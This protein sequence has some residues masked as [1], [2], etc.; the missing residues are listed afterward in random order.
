MNDL[1]DDT[2]RTTESTGTRQSDRVSMYRGDILT[3]A[4]CQRPLHTGHDHG[5][6][7]V[8]GVIR[9]PASNHEEDDQAQPGQGFGE[10]GGRIYTGANQVPA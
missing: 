6:I 1:L 4:Q 7:Q 9:E 8:P 5:E 10:D 2:K 3:L